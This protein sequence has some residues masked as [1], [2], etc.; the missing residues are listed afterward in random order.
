FFRIPEAL[1][2]IFSA[3]TTK[4]VFRFLGFS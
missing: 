2:I 1:N 3:A 4:F